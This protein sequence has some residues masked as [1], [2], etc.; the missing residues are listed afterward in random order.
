MVTEVGG[1]PG[2]GTS[3]ERG[4]GTGAGTAAGT[5]VGAGAGAA[6]GMDKAWPWRWWARRRAA[7]KCGCLGE[8]QFKGLTAK[9]H[10]HVLKCYY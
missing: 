5:A 1:F 3:K 4:A 6:G 7:A 9:F 2:T 8:K 10:H